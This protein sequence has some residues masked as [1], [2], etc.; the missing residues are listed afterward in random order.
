M[1]TALI[2]KIIFFFLFCLDLSSS[3]TEVTPDR[4]K[5]VAI[6]FYYYQINSFHHKLDLDKIEIL[7]IHIEKYENEPVYY[8]Y[9]FERGGFVIISAEDVLLPVFAYNFEGY[10]DPSHQNCNLSS[11][12]QH[13]TDMVIW[14]RESNLQ[15]EQK[16]QEQWQGLMQDHK[17]GP[18]EFPQWEVEPLMS[19]EWN[20]DVPYNSM[21]PDHPQGPGGKCLTGCVA[22]AI[23]QIMHY[24]RYPLVGSGSKS[25]ICQ[26]IGVL[27][28]D[29]SST[30]YSWNAMQN[31][32]ND[33]G[34][35]TSIQAVAQLLYHVGVAVEMQYSADASSSNNEKALEA[36]V[37]HFN[38]SPSATIA[39]KEFY[40][41]SSWEAVLKNNLDNGRPVYYAADNNEFGHAF[42][43]DGYQ[44]G[45]TTLFHFNFGWGGSG[46]GY[47]SVEDPNGFK[48]GQVIIRNLFPDQNNYT[49]PYHCSGHSIITS[50]TGSFEDGSGP[51]EHYRN[52]ISCSWLL[53]PQDDSIRFYSLEFEKIDTDIQDVITIYDG[54]NI[55]APVLG[56]FS[57]AMIP[58][59]LTSSGDRVLITF[60]S[61]DSN[62]ASGWKIKFRAHLPNFC[63]GSILLSDP[64]GTFS[65]GSQDKNYI[66]NSFCKWNI[67]IPDANS[68]TVEFEYFNTEPDHDFVRILD[69]STNPSTELGK[70]SGADLPEPVTGKGPLIVFFIT[71]QSINVQG[72]KA[73]YTKNNTDIGEEIF[74]KDLEI[75][76]NPAKNDLNLTFSCKQ[77][78]L[79]QF[80]ILDITGRVLIE[81]QLITKSGTNTFKYDITN[82]ENGIYMLKISNGSDVLVKKFLIN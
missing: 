75:F 79:Y 31:A 72:W 56:V 3:A 40:S 55:D 54:D 43:C 82:L 63:S 22:T 71:N 11:W 60:E 24:W 50:P 81:D 80:R 62:T 12:M 29:F 28:V 39:E 30:Y 35:S 21:C 38:Y 51:I 20:Q 70:F 26:G 1:R 5:S 10:F 6:H 36:F 69:L 14:A 44:T 25:Y 32:L 33:W 8:V 57:G 48:Y 49:Y 27:T 13:Y 4:A 65:D 67:A 23:G 76:P 17:R 46:D 37:N 9:N 66:E 64:S 58:D 45:E 19:S 15:S 53:I 68:I 78:K 16:V 2:I 41:Q 34:G 74:L 42:V 52:N 7:S 47:Y 77:S 73:Y 61:D 18:N 59:E